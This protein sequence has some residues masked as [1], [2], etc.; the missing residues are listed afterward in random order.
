LNNSL[1]GAASWGG[2]EKG[3]STV[4]AQRSVGIREKEEAYFYVKER[5]TTIP[6]E[7]RHENL[8]DLIHRVFFSGGK[9]G[10]VHSRGEV[11]FCTTKEGDD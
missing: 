11:V 1:R 5:Q 9:G 2:E 7:E 6:G 3:S 4:L 8:S 10:P